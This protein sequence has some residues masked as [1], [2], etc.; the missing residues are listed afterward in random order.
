MPANWDTTLRAIFER[1]FPESE[2][3]TWQSVKRLATEGDID[4][5]AV[6]VNDDIVG[7]VTIWK[8]TSRNVGEWLYIEYL[9]FAQQWRG[10][11]LGT[12]VMRGI[13]ETYGL[14]IV[15]EAEPSGFTP[16]ADARLR[17]YRRLGFEVHEDFPYTQPPY[18]PGLPPVEL[19]LLTYHRPHGLS[20]AEISRTLHEKVYKATGINQE[21]RINRD[22]S[23]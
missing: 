11:G 17:F 15:L 23:R 6:T 22:K 3:R 2:R 9:A 10:K 8:F 16:E 19:L 12:S 14:P 7:H 13:Q 4:A 18:S 21:I 5:L 1:S 20:L